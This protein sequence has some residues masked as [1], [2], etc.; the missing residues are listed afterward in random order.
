[1]LKSKWYFILGLPKAAAWAKPSQG[2]AMI[3]GFGLAQLL[4]KPKPWLLGQARP[5][6][7]YFYVQIQTH[8]DQ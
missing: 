5:E 4:G 8:W 1:M 7:H 3:G 6:Q 2:Q